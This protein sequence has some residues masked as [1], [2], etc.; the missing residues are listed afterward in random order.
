[1]ITSGS[2]SLPLGYSDP[3]V[4]GFGLYENHGRGKVFIPARLGDKDEG[5]Y[6]YNFGTIKVVNGGRLVPAGFE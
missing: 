6:F 4:R 5:L 2:Y 1:M 3:S